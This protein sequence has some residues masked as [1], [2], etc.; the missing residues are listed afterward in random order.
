MITVTVVTSRPITQR[1]PSLTQG[2]TLRGN[3]INSPLLLMKDAKSLTARVHQPSEAEVAAR[4]DPQVT[5]IKRAA[6]VLII[7]MLE[8]CLITLPHSKL[9]SVR[10]V[11][12]LDLKRVKLRRRALE[13][14]IESD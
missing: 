4:I 12:V 2:L 11:R 1:V 7:E 6:A 9:R 14:I 8:C 3:T 10:I 5:T 13:V